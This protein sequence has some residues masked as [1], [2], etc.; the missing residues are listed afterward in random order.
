MLELDPGDDYAAAQLRTAHV[1]SENTQAAIDVDLAI[2][3]DPDRDRA[4][5]RAAY[6]L[7]AQGQLDA[8]ITQL[9]QGRETRPD[10]LAIAEALGEAL[11]AAGKWTERAQL[12]AELAEVPGEQLDRDIAQLRSAIAWEEAVGAA[13]AL[14]AARRRSSARPRQRSPRGARARDQPDRRR[15]A[16]AIVLASRLGDREIISE[17]LT[18]AQAA[19]GGTGG[20]TG[21]SLTA[22]SLAFRRARLHADDLPRVESILR[23]TLPL[24]D[25]RRMVA[26]LLAAARSNDLGDAAGA[27]EERANQL[28]PEASHEIGALRLRAAQ[29]ALDAADAPRATRLLQQVEHALPQLG[30]VPD[31]L[32]AARRRAGDR[33]TAASA[34]A[35]RRAPGS[36]AGAA[37][38]FARIVRDADLAASHGD[39]AAALALYQRALELRPGDPL[40]TVPLVRVATEQREAGPLSALA[41]ARLR[42]AEDAGDGAGKAIAYEL[43]A[44]ID[45]ELRGDPGQAQIAL[46]SAAQSDPTRIDLMLRLERYYGDELSELLRLRRAELETVPTEIAKDRAA[47]Q[48][49]IAGLATREGRPELELAEIYREV[50]AI[51]PG[52]RLALLHLESI[53]RRS[54]FS[55]EL[56]ALEEKI[57]VYFEGDARSQAAFSTRAGETLSEI[58]QIDGAVQCFGRAEATLPGH[59]PALVGWRHAA[60]KG[61][62]WID[63]AE[64][65]TRQ[66]AALG[67]TASA[68]ARATLHHFA[69]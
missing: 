59:V 3:S 37:D 11:A 9:A 48:L 61:Q 25:P 53:V 45:G 55:E 16:A 40:A 54:G 7:I 65:A 28:D 2:A 44:Q 47:L 49:D 27:L 22:A 66:A 21:S 8:A 26:L 62:L 31:L 56:A 33:P 57:A 50:I 63:V 15:R 10:S 14:E 46:E 13:S 19:A 68:T 60:L 36:S 12:F 30:V 35:A 69:G 4:R 58:G 41:L 17:V 20:T 42:T 32:A 39:G 18:R 67:P 34:A 43:L 29:L 38:A 52:A 24:D 1:A 23:E 5:L 64:A 6:G 51:D